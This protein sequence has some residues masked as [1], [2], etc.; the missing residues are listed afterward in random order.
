MVALC[1]RRG[2][3][4]WARLI[5]GGLRGLTL[6]ALDCLYLLVF[7]ILTFGLLKRCTFGFLAAASA[8]PPVTPQLN[9]RASA[10]VRSRMFTLSRICGEP[11]IHLQKTHCRYQ[12]AEPACRPPE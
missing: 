2:D 3:Y 1:R 10:N 8:M 5:F 9:A 12:D 6:E 11:Q 7:W 4:R